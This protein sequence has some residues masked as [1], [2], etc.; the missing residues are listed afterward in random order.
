MTMN[1]S[2][3]FTPATQPEWLATMLANA[4]T[5][6]LQTTSWQ[7]GGMARTM[8]AIMSNVM[9]Q[10][11][12]T[13]S[14]MAQGGFL[15]YAASG[16]VTYVALN[17]Q[18]VTQPVTPDPSIPAQNP[19][20]TPGWLDVLCSSVYDV[21]RIGAQFA[22]GTQAIANTSASVYGPYE[23][24]T[25]HISNPTSGQGY[26]NSSQLTIAAA[27]IVGGAITAATN[28]SPIQITT[29]GAHGLTGSEVVY[30]E[31]VVGN[32]GANG[33]WEFVVNGANT[34]ILTG[35]VGNG[36]WTSGGTLNVCTTGTFAADVAGPN[37]TS[38]RGTI[39]EAVTTLTGV[40]VSNIESFFGA[41]WESNLA[42]A[43][44][45]R[46]KIQSLSP[47]GPKGAYAY[48]ALAAYQL[49]LDQDPAVVLS[50]PITKVLV[51][52][53]A[54]TGIVNTTLASTVG[55]VPGVSNLAVS[56][57]T[58]ATPIEI[59]ATAHGL[60]SGNYVQISSVLG[61]TNANGQW[62]ITVT[63]ANT[64]TLDGSAGNAA[65]TSGGIV[66]GGD[67]GEVDTI[68]QANC[69]PDG[70]T[71]ITDSS[72]NFNVAVVCN[73]SVP[74]AQAPAFAVAVQTAL[75]VYFASL[76]IGGNSGFLDYD[77]VLG[78]IISAG[79][80]N[81]QQSYVVSAS[82]LTLNGGSVD[83]AFPSPKHVAALSPTP[84]ITVTGV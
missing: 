78:V 41:A 48:F 59:S 67:L 47:N 42:L 31:G 34:I 3:L 38:T 24:G 43:A 49:L 6:N 52:A 57:A 36:A 81:G 20:G 39:T 76:P 14:V 13:V 37:G 45:A 29:S 17:G 79:S 22:T 7:S 25:Y 40:S 51:S 11:D 65:Y 58:N 62:V 68:I 74:Q 46:L 64:F 69:V 56:G 4:Q 16:T 27:N 21:T 30:I 8:L 32:T 50:S 35:S 82:G 28:T 60:A 15:D 77:V 9:S 1:I 55:A 61:N 54:T 71:A 44:R 18:T 53:S 5:L 33:F 19:T 75:A 26:N 23:P 2:E 73:V 83:L 72:T 80:I 84:V 70:N 63:G 66:Q 12:A 10:E